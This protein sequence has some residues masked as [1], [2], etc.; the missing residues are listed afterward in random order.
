MSFANLQSEPAAVQP[1]SGA[2]KLLHPEDISVGDE[3]T[4]AIESYDYPSFFWCMADP[5]IMPADETIR[6]SFIPSETSK[7]YKVVAVCLP[8][9]LCEKIDGK[10]TTFDVRKVQLMRLTPDFAEVARMSYVTKK[11]KKVLEA[12]KLQQQQAIAANEP[13]S[14]SFELGKGVAFVCPLPVDAEP[15]TVN[16][17]PE[18]GDALEEIGDAS[19]QV[20]LFEFTVQIPLADPEDVGGFFSVVV[21][22]S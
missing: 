11:R 10:F 17:L 4:P 16:A 8:F 22:Q 21:S 3:V 13:E 1:Q 19:A 5:A 14:D 15:V 12:E 9:V 7:P 18:A 20:V 6:L 2:A